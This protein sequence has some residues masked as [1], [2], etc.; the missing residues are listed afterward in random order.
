MDRLIVGPKPPLVNFPYGAVTKNREK[1]LRMASKIH[2]P[3]NQLKKMCSF[4][5]NF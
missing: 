2:P 5:L 4:I 3:I 1:K